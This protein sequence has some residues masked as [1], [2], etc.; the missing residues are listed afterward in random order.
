MAAIFLLAVAVRLFAIVYFRTYE[1]SPEMDHWNFGYEEGRIARSLVMGHGFSS[2]MPE[3]TGPTGYAAP[4]FP[5]VLAGFF[6]IFGEYTAASAVATYVFDALL[7]ALTCV[8]LYAL[9]TR[10]FERRVGLAAAFLFALYPPSIWHASGTIWDVTFLSFALVALM[11]CLYALPLVPTLR[12]LASIGLLMGLIV[13]INPA[14]AIFYPVIAGWIWYRMWRNSPEKWLS[15]QGVSILTAS[16]LLVCVPWMIRNAVVV[17]EF[18]PRS[19]TGLQ[20]WLGN[21]EGAWER[22]GAWSMD[23]DPPNS[24]EELKRFEELGDAGYDRYC[25]R[26]SGDFIRQNPSKFADLIGYRIRLWWLGTGGGDWK[27]N[28]RTSLR[29]ATMK[30]LMSLVLI[31]LAAIGCIVAWRRG[32][33]VGLMLALFL[34]YPIPYY[35][36]FVSERYRFPIEPFVLLAATFGV[37]EL[38]LGRQRHIFPRR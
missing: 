35:L 38:A 17:G 19:S 28:F 18:T 12:R 4:V 3:P 15:L 7:S 14:P 5:L 22:Q 1:I 21:N 20:L 34:I 31:P 9:G 33:P 32:K 8:A 16:C 26:L 11:S 2:P 24:P 36:F 29:L 37:M 6:R 27:G 25:Y 13:L 30:R 23:L 10:M